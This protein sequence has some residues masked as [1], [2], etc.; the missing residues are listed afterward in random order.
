MNSFSQTCSWIQ[1]TQTTLST[2]HKQLREQPERFPTLRLSPSPLP[3]RESF[4]NQDSNSVFWLSPF[5]LPHLVLTKHNCVPNTAQCLWRGNASGTD[6]IRS[7]SSFPTGHVRGSL[8]LGRA[9]PQLQAQGRASQWLG[10]GGHATKTSCDLQTLIPAASKWAGEKRLYT[11]KTN[12]PEEALVTTLWVGH[13]RLM[14]LM[15][16]STIRTQTR[17]LTLLASVFAFQLV[18]KEA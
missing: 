13:Y 4:W 7:C 14:V 17:H 16:G 6:R 5:S 10:C 18:L 1:K 9:K 12:M 15:S 8:P 2:E 3:V 11:V